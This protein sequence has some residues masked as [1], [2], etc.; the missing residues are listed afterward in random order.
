MSL[1]FKDEQTIEKII[2]NKINPLEKKVDRVL[3]VL[4]GF[5]GNVKSMQEE[6]TMVD[7]HKDQLE[8]HEERL[9]VLEDKLSVS[10]S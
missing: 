9:E 2:D 3:N 5:A 7:G 4:D 8:D 6:L 1:T 10:T